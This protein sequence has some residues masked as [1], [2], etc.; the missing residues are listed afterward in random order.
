M[1]KTRRDLLKISGA[2]LATG[3]AGC[4]T[5]NRD[6]NNNNTD[7][8]KKT[9]TDKTTVDNEL[10]EKNTTE[11]EE[12][13]EP[14][15]P[16]SYRAD[17]KRKASG[18]AELRNIGNYNTERNWDNLITN[19]EEIDQM[20]QDWLNEETYG[21]LIN[22][23][24]DGGELSEVTKVFPN[25][26]GD[27]DRGYF[28]QEAV[29]NEDDFETLIRWYLPAIMHYDGEKYGNAPSSRFMRFGATLEKLINQHHPEAEATATGVNSMPGHGIFGVQDTKNEEFYL[30]DTTSPAQYDGAVGRIGDFNTSGFDP[31]RELSRQN[32]W[33]PFHE[34][35]T[36]EQKVDLLY[37]ST[38]NSGMAG[39]VNFVDNRV[40]NN[41][42]NYDKNFITDEWMNEAYQVLRNGGSIQPITEPIEEMIYNNIKAE[43]PDF[44]GIY[45]TL[46]DTRIAVDSGD[47]I[48]QKVMYEPEPQ[49]I[50]NIESMLETA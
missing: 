37:S 22:Q 40:S 34:F 41:E 28:D 3:L 24:M 23:I 29:Q 15:I 7:T 18:R 20:Q 26:E 36:G 12:T 32:L 1:G 25:W 6:S 5:Q 47:E 16:E 43:E 39:L 48:Y 14:D 46:D 13:P 33:D 44:I 8:D 11:T 2:A 10:T 35:Q 4:Q 17:R 31:S 45:G 38:K 27:N 42:L 21:P 9:S 19:T 30:V 49:N 50:D